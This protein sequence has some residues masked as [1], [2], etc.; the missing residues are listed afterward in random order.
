MYNLQ[1][2][3]NGRYLMSTIL[4]SLQLETAEETQVAAEE[5]SWMLLSSLPFSVVTEGTMPLRN[6]Y[7]TLRAEAR[8]AI[9]ERA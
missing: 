2:H 6:Y 1:Q 4:N 7:K 9:N 8:R 5:I 3:Q